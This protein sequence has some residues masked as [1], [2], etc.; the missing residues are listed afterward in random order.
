M[1]Y[2]QTLSVVL[3]VVLLYL[4]GQASG[5]WRQR[6][7]KSQTGT[8]IIG[9]ETAVNGKWPWMAHIEFC[10]DQGRCYNCGGSLISDQWI[11]TAAHCVIDKKGAIINKITANFSNYDFTYDEWN[12][13]TFQVKQPIVHWLYKNY[14]LDDIALLEL[15]EP[16]DLNGMGIEPICLPPADLP[17]PVGTQCVATGWGDT[18]GN[19]ISPSKTLQQVTLPIANADLCANR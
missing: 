2:N 10:P 17:R 7:G 8:R 4:S 6:C 9:G 18:I 11:L 15:S 3:T 5:V 12:V 1:L 14:T 19:I 16:L 13:N